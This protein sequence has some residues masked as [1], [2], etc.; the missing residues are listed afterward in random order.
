[1]NQQT[2]GNTCIDIICI[3]VNTGNFLSGS[4]F[5]FFCGLS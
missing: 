5:G 4:I 2:Q 1:M 3:E